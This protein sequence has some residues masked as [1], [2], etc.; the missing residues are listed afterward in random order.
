MFAQLDNIFDVFGG[1][2]RASPLFTQLVKI[3][4]YGENELPLKEVRVQGHILISCPDQATLG[5]L[6]NA[7][8]I[9]TEVNKD[10]DAGAEISLLISLFSRVTN[11]PR[12]SNFRVISMMLTF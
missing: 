12:L 4:S 1:G 11:I 8:L 7:R 10:L 9:N 5:S 6:A 3:F 2:K